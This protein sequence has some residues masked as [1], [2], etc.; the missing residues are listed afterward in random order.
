M[1]DTNIFDL[2][3]I[4]NFAVS[5]GEIGI[6]HYF[7]NCYFQITN[8]PNMYLLAI[9]FKQGVMFSLNAVTINRSTGYAIMDAGK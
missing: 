8:N 6:F 9:L 4:Y 5:V 1:L 7:N 3:Q 2:T